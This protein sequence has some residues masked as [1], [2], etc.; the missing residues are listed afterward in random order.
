[1]MPGTYP[2]T[3]YRGDTY[4]F[5]VV[6]W[7]DPEQTDPVDLTGA[8]VAAEIRDKPSGTTIVSMTCTVTTPNIVDVALDADDAE[9]V[10][11]K[12]AWDLEITYPDGTVHTVLAGAV[13]AT[14]DVTHST[15]TLRT[16]RLRTA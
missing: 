2:L 8:T 14:A 4:T 11:L 9:L 10:P 5:R 16:T 6:L 7:A 3:L 15:T 12:G 13:T 1:M